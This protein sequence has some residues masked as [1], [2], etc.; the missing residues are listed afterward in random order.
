MLGD[1]LG[2]A[3]VRARYACRC[4]RPS[5]AAAQRPKNCRTS[6]KEPN[7]ERPLLSLPLA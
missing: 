2:N 3:G 1:C 5:V 4:L 7:H 6:H